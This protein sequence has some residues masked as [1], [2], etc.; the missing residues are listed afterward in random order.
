LHKNGWLQVNYDVPAKEAVD[1]SNWQIKRYQADADK[2]VLSDKRFVVLDEMIGFLKSKGSV[3]LVRLPTGPEIKG[4][5]EKSFPDFDERIHAVANGQQVSYLNLISE[6]GLYRTVDGN[7]IH[8]ED[9]ERLSERVCDL[10]KEIINEK[11]Y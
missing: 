10:I 4:I 9:V 3:V 6:S 8:R 7:H 5:E 11:G 2:Y 1:N